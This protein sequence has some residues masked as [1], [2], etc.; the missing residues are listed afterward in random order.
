MEALGITPEQVMAFA[1]KVRR[2]PM[3]P[4]FTTAHFIL[5]CISVKENIHREHHGNYFPLST[6]STFTLEPQRH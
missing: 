4:Y 3:W 1:V 6:K 2:Q 5:T